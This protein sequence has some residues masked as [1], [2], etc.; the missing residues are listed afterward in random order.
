MV[1]I[2]L[3]IAGIAA[4]IILPGFIA[5]TYSFASPKSGKIK[6]NINSCGFL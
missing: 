3:I 2:T 1:K 6:R 4:G 5:L